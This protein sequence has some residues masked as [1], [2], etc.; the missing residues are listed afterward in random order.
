[1]IKNSRIAKP[2]F[3][4]NFFGVTCSSFKKEDY[5]RPSRQA[6]LNVPF[7]GQ[8]GFGMIGKLEH[9]TSVYVHR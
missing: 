3:S 5:L 9:R 1:M 2:R 8:E 4:G 7:Q 6:R